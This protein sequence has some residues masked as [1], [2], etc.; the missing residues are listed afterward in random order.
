[1]LDLPVQKQNLRLHKGMHF[2][3]SE[4][5]MRDSISLYNNAGIIS[6]VSA[7]TASE[8]TKNCPPHENPMNIH[9]NLILPESRVI[10]L[11]FRR[12]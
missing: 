2:G 11:H 8:N 10:G 7:E 6:K 3:M 4:K 5:S 1:M 12:R 9:T